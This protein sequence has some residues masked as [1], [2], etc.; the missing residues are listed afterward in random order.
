MAA[1]VQQIP[2]M[3]DQMPASPPLA[4][5]H[6]LVQ[7]YGELMDSAA[8]TE[9]FKFPHERALGRAASKDGFPVPVFR[10]AGRNG[11]FARTRDVAAWLT[12]L[13][14]PSP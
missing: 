12:Q 9:F 13:A 6:A 1:W 8:L 11:W 2:A 14:P 5:E 4:A 3:A 10:L 7:R